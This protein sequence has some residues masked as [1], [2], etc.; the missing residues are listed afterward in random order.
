VVTAAAAVAP[1]NEHAA[2]QIENWDQYTGPTPGVAEQV[3]LIVPRADENGRACVM[4]HNA[5]ADRAASITFPI[6]ELPCLTIWKR[7][8]GLN[9]G[10]VTGLEPSTS[11]PNLKSFERKQGRVVRLEPGETY[12]ASLEITVHVDAPAVAATAERIKQLQH[13]APPQLYAGF[14]PVF[15]PPMASES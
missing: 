5:A 10:Y 11:Y 7:P 9:D 4:L 12:R 14:H 15:N 1:Q 3:Y 6:S 2:S 8:G 13:D